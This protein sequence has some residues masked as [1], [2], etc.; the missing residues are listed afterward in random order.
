MPL[1][2]EIRPSILQ[3]NF[4][5]IEHRAYRLRRMTTLQQSQNQILQICTHS[6]SQ[7]ARGKVIRG[8]V[9]R[10]TFLSFQYPT[11]QA[12]SDGG[13]AIFLLP[14]ENI[15]FQSVKQI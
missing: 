3:E 6:A 13:K 1:S 12:D 7:P 14:W 15:I 10:C 2:R 11:A 8:Q 4:A 5:G 9:R